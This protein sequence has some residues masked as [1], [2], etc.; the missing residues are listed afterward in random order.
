MVAL[1]WVV[2][3]YVRYM[4]IYVYM[5]YM[6]CQEHAL[7]WLVG[8]ENLDEHASVQRAFSLVLSFHI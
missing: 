5:V 4:N 8:D 2:K 6:T 1:P 3:C 7:L